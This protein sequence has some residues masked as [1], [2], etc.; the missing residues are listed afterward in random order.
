MPGIPPC[1][2]QPCSNNAIM[3]LSRYHRYGMKE[4]M[5]N[6]FNPPLRQLVKTSLKPFLIFTEEGQVI[7]QIFC[8]YF[9]SWLISLRAFFPDA[10]TESSHFSSGKQPATR[11][12]AAEMLSSQCERVKEQEPQA[13]CWHTGTRLL[14]QRS[15]AVVYCQLG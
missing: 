12:A 6:E 5:K 2:T 11:R 15:G 14:L 13:P 8:K 3:Q 7:K 9:G 4:S 1:P 10:L